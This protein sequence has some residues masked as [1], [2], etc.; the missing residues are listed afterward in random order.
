[1]NPYYNPTPWRNGLTEDDRPRSD[2][3]AGAT[4]SC[5]VEPAVGESSW[6]R[7]LTVR[8]AGIYG[9]NRFFAWAMGNPPGPGFDS[10]DLS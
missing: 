7:R 10:E 9:L 5:V 4:D 1:M 6:G 8:E 3:P 2:E